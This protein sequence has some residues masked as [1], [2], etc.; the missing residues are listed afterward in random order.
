[1]ASS[2][3][4]SDEI[5]LARFRGVFDGLRPIIPHRPGCDRD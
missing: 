1:M 5:T 4:R 3:Q 2:R